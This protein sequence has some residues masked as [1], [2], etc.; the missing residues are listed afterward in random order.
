MGWRVAG[1]DDSEG[2]RLGITMEWV[3]V[4]VVVV[5]WMIGLAEGEGDGDLLSAERDLM[6]RSSR[7][8]RSNVD[9]VWR[10][11]TAAVLA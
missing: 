4:V 3:V 11:A 5:V 7:A 8:M 10:A 2:R 9:S 1:E 6:R